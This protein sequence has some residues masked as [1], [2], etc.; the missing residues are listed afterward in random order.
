MV[1]WKARTSCTPTKSGPVL[2]IGSEEICC[3]LCA[4]RS[5]AACSALAA[6]HS[7]FSKFQVMTENM[8]AP[9]ALPPD[10]GC[11]SVASVPSQ[12]DLLGRST[13]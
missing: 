7:K 3:N 1:E 5:L 6:G 2:V 10:G 4:Y 8:P 12:C 9:S 11:S 13:G